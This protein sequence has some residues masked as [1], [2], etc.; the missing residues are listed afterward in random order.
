MQNKSI[1]TLCHSEIQNILFYRTVT[2]NDM[3]F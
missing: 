1:T 2:W 3:K